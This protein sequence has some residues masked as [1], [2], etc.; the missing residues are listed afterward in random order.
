LDRSAH[1][2]AKYRSAHIASEKAPPAARVWV[3]T[4]ISKVR[5]TGTGEAASAE[6]NSVF[7]ASPVLQPRNY[8]ASSAA[9]ALK[10]HEAIAN[11]ARDFQSTLAISTR[12]NNRKIKAQTEV[13]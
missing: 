1:N 4:I 10:R 3:I 9:C 13:A 6:R 2:H 11:Y 8:N 7:V 12:P 5:R